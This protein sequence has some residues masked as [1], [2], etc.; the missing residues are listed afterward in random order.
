MKNILFSCDGIIGYKEELEKEMKK[1]FEI[2][3]YIEEFPIKEERNLY[4]KLLRE[5]NKKNCFKSY[6]NEYIKK[7][8]ERLLKK[9]KKDTFDYFFIVAGKIF[10]IEFIKEL[11]KYNSRLKIILFLWDKL[12][13]TEL[14]SMIKE[15][16]Y[17]FSFEKQDCIKYS[18]IFRP[19]FYLRK[20]E[21]NK[22]IYN[23]RK[24]D[25]YYIGALRDKE[26]YEIVK[27]IY[28]YAQENE[29]NVFLKL[30]VDG[31]SKKY[32]PANYEK[33]IVINKKISYKK[34]LKILKEAKVILDINYYEQLGLS[35]RNFE[36]IG[37][38]TKI[39]TL[40]NTIKE[41]DFYNE[42]NIYCIEK[43]EDISLIPKE[44]F[45]EE[46]K[47]LSENIKNKYTVQGFIEEI[48]RIIEK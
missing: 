5:L 25:I 10:S 27:R 20:L 21:N 45:I 13:Y 42:K 35:L 16:D 38:D 37:N 23:E 32:L 48:F 3:Q 47:K 34:N 40:N 12:E 9:Y 29:F 26:R 7:Y 15:C 28:D 8:Q 1:R 33:N 24:Y 39:I 44:F 2:V 31:K 19:S 18:F 43:I 30:Y 46:Y 22:K 4:F 36:A 14:K 11:K 6:Y 41:Y 17:I